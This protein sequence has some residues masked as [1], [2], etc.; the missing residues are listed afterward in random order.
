[1]FG[2]DDAEWNVELPS[3]AD[4]STLGDTLE[5]SF[6]GKVEVPIE[7]QYEDLV[8]ETTI[9][10]FVQ[11]V[12]NASAVGCGGDLE[13]GSACGGGAALILFGLGLRSRQRRRS[14]G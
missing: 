10:G 3:R 1:M 2:F 5:Y 12:G 7:V 14:S 4:D 6:Q 9:H 13:S 8:A 11:D